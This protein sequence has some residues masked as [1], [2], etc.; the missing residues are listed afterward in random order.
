MRQ[1]P[2]PTSPGL[3]LA[4]LTVPTWPSLVKRTHLFDHIDYVRQRGAKVRWIHGPSGAGKATLAANDLRGRN[5]PSPWYQL[6]TGDA[7]PVSL[8]HYL[9]LAGQSQDV[10]ETFGRRALKALG[11]EGAREAAHQRLLNLF[12]NLTSIVISL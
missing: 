2:T 5:L 9:R 7:N 8:F 4:K 11:V 1:D 3:S 10:T 12:I 6:D